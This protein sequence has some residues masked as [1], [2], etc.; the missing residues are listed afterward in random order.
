MGKGC[1][2]FEIQKQK[3]Q[4]LQKKF[5]VMIKKNRSRQKQNTAF[6]TALFGYDLIDLRRNIYFLFHNFTVN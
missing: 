4:Y 5:F 6:P 2:I 1:R 3:I